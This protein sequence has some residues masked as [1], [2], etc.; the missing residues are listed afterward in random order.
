MKCA[1]GFP[2]WKAPQAESI[3]MPD[4][5]GNYLQGHTKPILNESF[6]IISKLER[7]QSNLDALSTGLK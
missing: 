2:H 5:Y 6:F 4:C 3:V 7:S 1:T